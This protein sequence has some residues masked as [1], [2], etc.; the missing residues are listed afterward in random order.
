MQNVFRKHVFYYYLKILL[1]FNFTFCSRD[2]I[3]FPNSKNK[4]YSKSKRKSQNSK[5]INT[6]K[7]ISNDFD[8]I[9]LTNEKNNFYE[10]FEYSEEIFKNN[11]KD[12][13]NII[14]INNEIK[15][16]EIENNR[17]ETMNKTISIKNN[18]KISKEEV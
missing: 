9:D 8:F 17:R 4:I 16:T 7:I 5:K 12:N 18:F 1:D 6:N 15:Q 13:N 3:L 14:T 10:E 11:K 2:S